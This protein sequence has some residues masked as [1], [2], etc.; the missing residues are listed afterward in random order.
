M[1]I[2]RFP[3]FRHQDILTFR[4]VRLGCQGEF[5][6]GL[7]E[8]AG[9]KRGR[10]L[11]IPDGRPAATLVKEGEPVVLDFGWGENSLKLDARVQK[12]E[13]DADGLIG[14]VDLV[15]FPSQPS[16]ETQFSQLLAELW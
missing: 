12:V 4:P 8:G 1:N 5:W 13:W 3:P 11:I 6:E 2:H 14:Q 16:V 15:F 9:Q 10:F 7:W